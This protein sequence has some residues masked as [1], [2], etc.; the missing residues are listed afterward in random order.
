MGN[1]IEVYFQHETS[2]Y[3]LVRGKQIINKSLGNENKNDVTEDLNKP[4][5]QNKN[6]LITSDIY[7]NNNSYRLFIQYSKYIF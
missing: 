6:K 3:G 5:H 7:N 2:A 1:N 4:N